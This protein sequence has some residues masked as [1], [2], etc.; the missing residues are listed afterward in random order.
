MV[1]IVL[2]VG[3]I[4]SEDS[5]GLRLINHELLKLNNVVVVVVANGWFTYYHK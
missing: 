5:I 4:I 1:P 2:P 3:V